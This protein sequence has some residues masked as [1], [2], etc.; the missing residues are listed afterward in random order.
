MYIENPQYPPIE[1]SLDTIGQTILRQALSGN[2]GAD[3]NKTTDE[4]RAHFSFFTDSQIAKKWCTENGSVD[5]FQED[6][7]GI[8]LSV[9]IFP[10]DNAQTEDFEQTKQKLSNLKQEYI[11]LK[12]SP[13]EQYVLVPLGIIYENRN[14]QSAVL[15][16]F[17]RA[18]FVDWNQ[19]IVV[20]P[21]NVDE[22]KD[23]AFISFYPT[24]L[25][26]LGMYYNIS[27]KRKGND[28]LY[29][30]TICIIKKEAIN[31][32]LGHL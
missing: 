20:T 31:Q 11:Y 9:P 28:N 13:E 3:D 17:Q 22:S 18:F 15:S 5:F 10:E 8:P 27:R 25:S 2:F 14:I 12:N 16:I 7:D 21:P 23:K 19:P 24:A 26:H 29:V 4:T 30:H 1:A 6:F 32:L